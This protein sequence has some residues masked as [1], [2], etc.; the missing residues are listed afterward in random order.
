M[1]NLRLNRVAPLTFFFVHFLCTVCAAGSS[2][3]PQRLCCEN[4]E[5]PLG[6]DSP[7]PRLSWILRAVDPNAKELRQSAYHILVASSGE[8]LDAHQGDLWDSGK[9]VSDATHSIAYDGG[10]LNSSQAVFWKVR[11]WDQDGNVSGWSSASHWVMGIL[12]PEDWKAKWITASDFEEFDLMP[13]KLGYHGKESREQDAVQWVQ[14]DLGKSRTLQSVRLCPMFHAEKKGFGFPIRFKLELS[15]DPEFSSSEL[16]ADHTSKDYENPGLKPVDFPV[17]NISARYVRLTANKLWPRGDGVYCLALRQL[18]AFSGEKNV[19]LKTPVR[20]LDSVDDF[21]WGIQG[22]TDGVMSSSVS[23]NDTRYASMM[24]RNDFFV[25]PGLKRAVV[26]ISGL[27]HY[28]LSV[29]GKKVGVDL[30]SPGWTDYRK[31]ILYDTYDITEQLRQGDN[32][33]GI[34]IANGMYH[35]LHTPGR[36]NKFEGTFGLIKAIAQ[37]RLEYADGSVQIVGTDESWRVQN[38][39]ATYSDV[40]GG[41]DF[42]ARALP[43]GW[44]RP[45]F[46]AKHW[47]S[48]RKIEGPGG[49]LRG[50]SFSNPPI[51]AFEVLTP[52]EKRELKP[53]VVVYDMG[54]NASIIPRLRV[55]GSA[56]DIVRMIPGELLHENGSVNQASGGGPSYWQYTL[57]GDAS[58][59]SYF[60][61]FFYRG[62]RYLQLET[63]PVDNGNG[64]PPQVESLE[65][66][67][68]H[69]DCT[70]IGS[71]ESSS[72]LFN[73]TWTLIRWA[74]RSNMFSVMTDCPHREKLGWLEE[75]HLNGPALRYNFD[76]T[77]L[78]AKI[79]N[80]MKDAQTATGMVPSIAPEYV[81]FGGEGDQNGF[82]NSPE[83]GSSLILVPWQQYLF[84]GETKLFEQYYDCMTAYMNYLQS[85]ANGHILDFGLGDWFA[86]GEDTPATITG[87]A[88]YYQDAYVMSIIARLLGKDD[89]ARRY[90]LLSKQISRAFNDKF[91]D[92]KSG[93]YQ[94]NTQTANAM[95]LALGM[96]PAEHRDSVLAA[97]VKN[98]RERGNALTSGDVGYRY[99]LRALADHGRSDVIFDMNNHS[100]RPGYG[101]QLAR[102]A[103]SLTE[104]WDANPGPSQNHFMLGQI[105]EWFFHDLAGIRPDETAPGF[106]TVIIQP[107]FVGDLTSVRARYDS[108]VGPIVS[109]WERKEKTVILSVELPPNVEAS[110]RLPTPAEGD[111]KPE[112]RSGNEHTYKIG[113][114]KHVF[115]I[116]V[117]P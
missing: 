71:F 110:V 66:V 17:K 109:Q 106:K 116:K 33:A 18:A 68:V 59:E 112:S 78:M 114:G 16:L 87:T 48:A 40:Y 20:A 108:I 58:E 36:Y 1:M 64:K 27:G 31:T 105:N 73:R 69:A 24:L 26:H 23:Q 9:I 14:V 32:A 67:V 84:S 101:M 97:I 77:M 49:V 43:N 25:K 80:D 56:G 81:K 102:G 53:N 72:E 21:G 75:D 91:F 7:K 37:L 95:P 86:I 63:I 107:A 42:D 88:T 104:A 117:D 115:Q 100:D 99:L 13:K 10:E 61:K 12:K 57:R 90:D 2:I 5:N 76:M 19:A 96:V 50:L 35:V 111:W 94:P 28:E 11:V 85:K 89:D 79:V 62:A 70:P 30:L 83:W 92:P 52:L 103:T 55:K 8:N 93:T 113:S 41:E 38:G 74:Q 6:I 47:I 60:S 51:R 34:M 46:D 65:N 4:R 15:D 29:N 44:D 39:P 82:R 98:V 54:Q 3:V 22:L 45:G